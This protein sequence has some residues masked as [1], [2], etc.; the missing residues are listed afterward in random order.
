MIEKLKKLS[1]KLTMLSNSAYERSLVRL[2]GY[3]S[4]LHDAYE[5]ASELVDDLLS[6]YSGKFLYQGCANC[7]DSELSGERPSC[8]RCIGSG[9]S[10]NNWR[11]TDITGVTEV[12]DEN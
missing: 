7:V 4:G 2:D 10:Q 5:G 1:K 3:D 9:G 6:E 11:P 12:L 8:V